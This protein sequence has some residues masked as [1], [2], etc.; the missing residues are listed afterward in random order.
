VATC[1]SQKEVVETAFFIAQEAPARRDDGGR[2]GRGGG[3][4]GRGGRD[5]GRGAG[6]GGAPA[7]GRGAAF[8]GGGRGPR[9]FAPNI[10]DSSAFPTLGGGN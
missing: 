8:G 5:G 4:G 7:G 9:G 2:G 6:R 10:G 1:A 3:R